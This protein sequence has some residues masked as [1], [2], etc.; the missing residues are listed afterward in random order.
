MQKRKLYASF[1][2]IISRILYLYANLSRTRITPSLKRSIAIW[3]EVGTLSILLPFSLHH[4]GF[5]SFSPLRGSP[6]CS[7]F[8]GPKPKAV[9]S[10]GFSRLSGSLAGSGG[11]VSVAL[12]VARLYGLFPRPQTLSAMFPIRCPDFPPPL[13]RVR[14]SPAS[15]GVR[16]V[17]RG[18]GKASE[19]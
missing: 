18:E 10:K 12:S 17:L 19:K 4:M 7:Q 11:M 8:Y 5:A 2:R 13:Q 3:T 16:I 9:T 1:H 6:F 14:I 15:E